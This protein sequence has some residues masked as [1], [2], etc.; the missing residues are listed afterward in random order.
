MKLSN[1]SRQWNINFLKAAHDCEMDLLTSFFTL[2]YSV[3]VRQGSEDRLCWV[4]F[5]RGLFH[6]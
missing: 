3:R 4:P 2:L 6:V 5:K 1:A